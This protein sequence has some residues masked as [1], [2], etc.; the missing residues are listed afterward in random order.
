MNP[1]LLLAVIG[2]GAS[3]V[4]TFKILGAGLVGPPSPGSIISVLAMTAKG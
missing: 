1:V 4:L 2:G 3:G